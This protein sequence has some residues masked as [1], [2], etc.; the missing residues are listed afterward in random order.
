MPPNGAVAFDS[1][2]RKEN[3]MKKRNA[4]LQGWK[5][6]SVVG[7]KPV[8]TV[9]SYYDENG[10]RQHKTKIEWVEDESMREY[11]IRDGAPVSETEL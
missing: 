11:R 6:I 9:S 7:M 5:D 10:K 3:D 8:K 2:P 1:N 4:V